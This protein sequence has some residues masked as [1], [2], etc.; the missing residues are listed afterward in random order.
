MG[1]ARQAGN[2]ENVSSL[3]REKTEKVLSPFPQTC[4]LSP[5]RCIRQMCTRPPDPCNAAGTNKKPEVF[6]WFMLAE[7]AGIEPARRLPDLTV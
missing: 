1:T 3:F 6:L 5:D 2:T 7:K 4:R